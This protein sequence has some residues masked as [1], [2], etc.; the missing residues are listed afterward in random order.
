MSYL[1]LLLLLA[2]LAVS[3][4]LLIA[5]FGPIGV[6]L[7]ES[8]PT[9]PGGLKKVIKWTI[10]AVLWLIPLLSF[11]DTRVERMELAGIYVILTALVFVALAESGQDKEDKR[12][13][14]LYQER[15]FESE[16]DEDKQRNLELRD[17]TDAKLA[18]RANERLTFAVVIGILGALLVLGLYGFN[19]F[20]HHGIN[21]DLDYIHEAFHGDG[22]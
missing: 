14:S 13:R 21:S 17:K 5:V 3:V 6:A 11:R 2:I 16:T 1:T 8:E 22:Y 15:V 19:C 20:L 10:A 18:Y 9:W 12:Q 7:F 4:T